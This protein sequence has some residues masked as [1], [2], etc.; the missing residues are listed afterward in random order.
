MGDEEKVPTRLNAKQRRKSRPNT[1]EELRLKRQR[2]KA[3]ERKAKKSMS[4]KE[5][6][7]FQKFEKQKKKHQEEM[8]QKP[9]TLWRKGSGQ[10][11]TGRN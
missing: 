6:K 2:R 1:L 9:S 8:T 7:F 4:K 10:Y 5:K 3:K 11:F